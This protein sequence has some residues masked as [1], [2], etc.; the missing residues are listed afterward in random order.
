MEA[1]VADPIH[2]RDRVVDLV[3]GPKP[4]HAMEQV[5]DAPL[6]EVGEHQEHEE[7][8]EKGPAGHRRAFEPEP[9]G[10]K[11]ARGRECGRTRERRGPDREEVAVERDEP[12]VAQPARTKD[13]LVLA[14]REQALE[15]HERRRDAHQPMEVGHG[16]EDGTMGLEA[17]SSRRAT[18]AAMVAPPKIAPITTKLLGA[19]SAR[20]V[21]PWPTVQPVAMDAPV[22]RPKPPAKRFRRAAARRAERDRSVLPRPQPTAEQDPQHEQT[23]PGWEWMPGEGREKAGR[24]RND[25]EAEVSSRGRGHGPSQRG[26]G[27]D[28]KPGLAPGPRT[29]AAVRPPRQCGQQQ[30]ASTDRDD[31]RRTPGSGAGDRFL[32]RGANAEERTGVGGGRPQRHTEN[33]QQRPDVAGAQLVPDARGAP[34]RPAHRGSEQEPADHCPEKR[35][36]QFHRTGKA[37][38]EYRRQ[39]KELHGHRQA[40]GLDLRPITFGRAAEAGVHAERSALRAVAEGRPHHERAGKAEIAHGASPAITGR[41]RARHSTTPSPSAT[42]W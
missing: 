5:V 41:P 30:E 15:Q 7:L 25:R 23:V 20:P 34:S 19:R 24:A 27:A 38:R 11:R 22:P 14:P 31:Q 16:Q 18:S 13:G 6:E 37:R 9:E 1:P 21:R 39:Q 29:R 3:E 35:Q 10:M 4:R 42:A 40:Q 26:Y 36:R 17:V 8:R 12:H 28:P 32:Q 2:G 33:R